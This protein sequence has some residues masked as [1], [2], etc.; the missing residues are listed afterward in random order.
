MSTTQAPP[1]SCLAQADLVLL[2]AELLAGPVSALPTEDELSHLLACARLGD[3]AL[4]DAMFDLLKLAGETRE[5]DW[6]D[7]QARLFEG[8]TPCPL[9]ETAYIRRD[10][11]VI[12]ADING[13][14]LA[15]GFELRSGRDDKCDHILAE[16]E[17]AALLLSMSALA[18]DDEHRG[19][20][21]D[22]L[23]AFAADHLSEWLALFTSRLQSISL[24][25]LHQSL[26]RALLLSWNALA[27][28]HDFP[29]SSPPAHFSLPQLEEAPASEDAL[30][31]CNPNS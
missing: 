11:G 28:R 1:S 29:P 18:D 4:R 20:T 3:D 5:D 25:P 26:S 17:F 23:K 14:Y 16:L 21:L 12:L 24:L 9:N 6:R 7:A 10:K 30:W 19:I 13:F 22:A 15:F 8:A 2:L 27:A 31:E